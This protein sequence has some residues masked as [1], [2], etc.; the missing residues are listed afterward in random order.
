MYNTSLLL[1]SS[2]R[3]PWLQYDLGNEKGNN[4]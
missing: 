2:A 1:Q 3:V 4:P